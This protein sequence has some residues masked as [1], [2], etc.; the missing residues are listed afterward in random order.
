MFA[1]DVLLDLSLAS[2]AALAFLM[3]ILVYRRNPFI[4]AAQAFL[5][6]MI[7]LSLCAVCSLLFFNATSPD[8]ATFYL[9]GLFFVL[10][11]MS[12]GF[13]YIASLP[14]SSGGAGWLFKQRIFYILVLTMTAAISSLSIS[15]LVEERGRYE[16]PSL[17]AIVV[18]I[19]VTVCLT[20]ATVTILY[21]LRKEQDDPRTRRQLSWLMAAVVL[22]TLGVAVIKISN[23]S[24]TNPPL[25]LTIALMVTS[26]AFMLAV[27]R[28]RPF[29]AVPAKGSG[30]RLRPPS[31]V[32]AA[33]AGIPDARVVLVEGKFARPAYEMM[34]AEVAAGSP[35]LFVTCTHPDILREQADVGD[36]S[37]I[38][39]A[40]QPGPDRID[41]SNLSI[42]EHF[43]SEFMRDHR[44]PAVLID[45]LEYLITSNDFERVLRF[46]FSIKDEAIMANAFLALPMDPQVLRPEQL[47]EME[48]ELEV[49]SYE[50][51]GRDRDLNSG[52]GIHSPTG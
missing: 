26:I 38:W 17:T 4:E 43:I 41:P 49:L 16:V 27:L 29:Q 24:L 18:P 51:R 37:V 14:P 1:G 46:L 30:I 5:L 20:I 33:E 22:P 21:S 7:M 47:A 8:V 9:R 19:S 52:L 10:V 15:G 31:A 39:L 13:L 44:R 12:G 34:A 36:A 35:A 42:L 2:V 48:R 40:S 32:P 45:G 28:V 50:E 11:L 6:T 25:I 3:G 23:A